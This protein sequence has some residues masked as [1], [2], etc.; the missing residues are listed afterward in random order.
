MEEKNKTTKTLSIEEEEKEVKSYIYDDP[1]KDVPKK[2]HEGINN[3]YALLNTML[4][5]KNWEEIQKKEG[6]TITKAN[7]KTGEGWFSSTSIPVV[8]GELD[9]ECTPWE[10]RRIQNDLD[11]RKERDPVLEEVTELESFNSSTKLV[12]L[13]YRGQW[14]VAPREILQLTTSRLEKDGTLK[15]FSYSVEDDKYPLRKGNVRTQV[16]MTGY[17]IKPIE[18]SN[19]CNVLH[20]SAL[21]LGGWVPAWLNEM[22]TTSA[23]L[24]LSKI[25]R[26]LKRE[27]RIWDLEKENE[28]LKKEIALLK[29]K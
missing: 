14:K 25:S 1:L 2:F 26:I 3:A 21:N 19:K 17:V 5:E 24:T 11:Y 9:I 15:I 13:L 27:K 23:P 18:N 8:K 10:F 4:K 12:F 28:A 6:V 20:I 7:I 22:V 16:I 29:N